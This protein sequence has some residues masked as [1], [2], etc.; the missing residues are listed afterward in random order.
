MTEYDYAFLRLRAPDQ[1]EALTSVR[2]ELL[3]WFAGHRPP[4][5]RVSGLFVP[6]LGWSYKQVALLI[7]RD[8]DAAADDAFL[9]NLAGLPQ[10][11]SCNVRR[12]LPTIRPLPGDTLTPGGIYVHRWMDVRA[13]DVDEFIALAAE[14][15][16]AG[17]LGE[18]FDARAFGLFRERTDQPVQRMLLLT[19][20]GSHADWEA[21]RVATPSRSQGEWE[22]AGRPAATARQAL[23]RRSALTLDSVPASTL[24]V[25]P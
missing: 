9:E 12:V 22:A 13:T 24:L 8:D 15:W 18:N 11:E 23:T 16:S 21:S 19:R 1:L 7:E 14:A 17:G 4:I 5:G 10:V 25:G 2:S 3:Q 6:Q 20:Y